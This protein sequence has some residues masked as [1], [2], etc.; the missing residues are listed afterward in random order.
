MKRR[1]YASLAAFKGALLAATLFAAPAFAQT[2]T[3]EGAKQLQDALSKT[4]GPAMFDK[5]VVSITPQGAAYAVKVDFNALRGE[6]DKAGVTINI[7]PLVYMATPNADGTYGVTSDSPIDYSMSRKG[8]K[9]IDASFKLDGCKSTG[10]FDPKISAFSSYD[11]SCPGASLIVHSPE[12]DIEASY[13]AITTKLTGRSAGPDGTTISVDGVLNDFVET[14]VLKD[15]ETPLTITIKAKSGVQSAAIDNLRVAPALDLV[16]LA[17][18]A[19]GRKNLIAQQDAIKQKLLAA[20]PL[21]DNMS[22]RLTLSD[23][24][25]GTPMGEFKLGSLEE[26]LGVTGVVKD[27]TYGIGLKYAGLELPEG[28]VPAWATPLVPTQGNID[29]KFS[30]VDLDGLARL[31]IQNFDATKKPPIPDSLKGQFLAIA[32]SGQP[33][34]TLSPSTFTASSGAVSAE[35]TMSV[36]PSQTGKV[37]ISATNLDQIIASINKADVPNKDQAMMGIALLKG[38]A[39]SSP[40]GKAIWDVDFD[41]ATQAVSVN[42]QVLSAGKGGDDQ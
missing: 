19:G 3:P 41:A 4:F 28:P 33:H 17:A 1:D 15:S 31:A 24:S 25:V 13:G 37:T 9:P 23:V 11:V 18:N 14:V 26:T 36:F 2:A 21:W 10:V 42:G 38:L 5:G 39:R 32:L 6:A 34:V 12:Q 22:G 40:D 7:G 27:A 20:L 35:G 16:S 29:V 8:D 30:G